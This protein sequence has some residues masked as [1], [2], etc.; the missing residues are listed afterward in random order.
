MLGSPIVTISVPRSRCWPGAGWGGDDD[1]GEV[2]E[3]DA[4]APLPEEMEEEKEEEE[5]GVSPSL[6]A[7]VTST[8]TIVVNAFHQTFASNIDYC[9]RS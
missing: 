8:L 1:G 9:V 6:P 7:L 3:E 5:E 2:E 4:A